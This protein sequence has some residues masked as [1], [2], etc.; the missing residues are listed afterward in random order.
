MLTLDSKRNLNT[1]HVPL[2]FILLCFA[3]GCVT[4]TK[5]T[6]SVTEYE[7]NDMIREHYDTDLFSA[8]IRPLCKLNWLKIPG[9]VKFYRGRDELLETNELS[10]S[11]RYCRQQKW[12]QLQFII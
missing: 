4:L 8:S 7:D 12:Q 3:E 1:T 9:Y 10:F 6:K 2:T 11:E 5:F